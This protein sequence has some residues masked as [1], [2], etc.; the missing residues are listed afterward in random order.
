MGL[1]GQC[2]RIV[3]HQLSRPFEIRERCAVVAA[4]VERPRA[5]YVRVRKIRPRRERCGCVRCGSGE[6]AAQIADSCVQ[7]LELGMIPRARRVW[8]RQLEC[9]RPTFSQ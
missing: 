7:A 4:S 6:V 3:G 9:L 5:L 1:R 2:L 8:R